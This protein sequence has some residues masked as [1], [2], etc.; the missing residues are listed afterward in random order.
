M[1]NEPGQEGRSWW[2]LILPNGVKLY[3]T[4]RQRPDDFIV[5]MNMLYATAGEV[6]YLRLLLNHYATRKLKDLLIQKQ[7]HDNQEEHDSFITIQ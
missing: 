3:I 1:Q 5:R 7:F 4:K 6:Y 2:S